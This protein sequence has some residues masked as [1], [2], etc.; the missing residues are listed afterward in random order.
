MALP[1]MHSTRLQK[2]I[3]LQISS[4]PTANFSNNNR[5]EVAAF[6]ME[7]Q[8][9]AAPFLPPRKEKNCGKYS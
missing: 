8:P 7:D 9:L 4:Y 5:S 1:T 6:L 2:G 3:S